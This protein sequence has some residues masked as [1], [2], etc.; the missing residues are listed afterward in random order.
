[1]IN[2][3]NININNNITQKGSWQN[4]LYINILTGLKRFSFTFEKR[5]SELYTL[6]TFYEYI[7]AFSLVTIY[8]I[9]QN[10]NY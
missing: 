8:L 2:K 4:N 6:K 5:S 1:M 10:S 7:T 9:E 3:T